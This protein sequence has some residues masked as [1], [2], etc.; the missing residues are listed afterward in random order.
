MV[1]VPQLITDLALILGAAG[2]TTLVFR[3][4]KQPLVLGY[5]LAG[6]LVG[7][8]FPLLPTIAE[9]ESIRV[10][11]ELG[12]IFLLFGLGLEFSFKKLA[13][14]GGAAAVTG[15]VE[16]GAMLLLGYGVGS[17]LGWSTMD[18]L[19]LG[20]I[21]AISS[22]T[23]ILR[24]FDEGGLKSQQFVGLVFGILIVEDLVAIL[25]LVLLSTLA[26]SQQFA[27]TT[28][29][30]SMLKLGFFLVVWFL[31][32]IYLIPS[33][34]RRYRQVIS[35]ETLLVLSLGLCLLMVVL[36]TRAGFSAALGAFVMGSILAETVFV[37]KI[38]HLLAPIKDLFGAVFFVS[39]GMLIDPR[40]LLVYA[41]PVALLSLVV[42]VGKSVNVTLGAL[43]SGQ[44]LKQ[45]LQ[46]GLSMAQIGEF[47]FIIATLGLTLKVTSEFLYPIAV[48]VSAV[49]TFTTPYLMRL[50]GPL[51]R[52]LERRLPPHWL[53][54]LNNYSRNTQTLAGVSD[55]QAVLRPFIQSILIHS[56]VIVGLILL[57]TR[58]LLPWMQS[59][60]VAA[61]WGE[62][63]TAAVAL[64]LMS[65]FLW[66]L[67]LRRLRTPAYGRL[68]K[69]RKFNRGPLVALEGSRIA[70]GI[71]LIGF[72]LDRLFSPVMAL[73]GAVALLLLVLPLLTGRLQK[74]YARIERRF[75]YNLHAREWDKKAVARSLVPWDT[76]LTE[77]AV[78]PHSPDIGK[79]LT[80]LAYRERYGVNVARIERGNATLIAPRG[81][82]RIFPYDRLTVI[83][84][85]AQLARFRPR[86]EPP[87]PAPASPPEVALRQL[88][89][90]DKFPFVGQS[91]RSSR[92]REKTHGMVVGIE[93]NGQRM[94]NPDPGTVFEKGD[95]VWLSGDKQL[96]RHVGQGDGLDLPVEGRVSP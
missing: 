28:L 88:L 55:W 29:L 52:V 82:D 2:V 39:V 5:L 10:W 84:T 22:T 65:P 38:E 13:K 8:N 81:T 67:S 24:A 45:S 33:F 73:A 89:V 68:W 46:T 42:I 40:L 7:P 66:A 30:L 83:G 11:A 58:L 76:H 54:F 14:V 34:L 27:G 41:G 9:T 59:H 32:G 86:V 64:F 16:I 20:G 25:L 47:S 75:L 31:A 3:R 6:L 50:A 61:P 90:D 51:Y 62:I 43:L 69:D 36:V 71:F 91:I 23:I 17:A 15:G 79:T 26:V 44:P 48:A 63:I 53:V 72:L 70:L 49:T 60:R 94:V 95:L 74:T 77:F 57:A 85:D 80:E 87:E 92:I 37:E 78:S 1:H 35:N 56:A 18:S 21:I 12:V 96:L 4:F 93:R 19:F